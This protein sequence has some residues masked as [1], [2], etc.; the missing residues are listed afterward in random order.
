LAKWD[1]SYN[2]DN[3]SAHQSNPERTLESGDGIFMK[4]LLVAPCQ[5][6]L[7]DPTQGHSLIGVFHEIKIQIPSNAPEL[8]N[9]AIVPREWA[10]FSKFELD[11]DEEGKNYSMTTQFYWP[12]G[13]EFANQVLVA[14]QPTKNGMAFIS[15]FQGFPMGQNGTLKVIATLR[16]DDEVVC[17]PT[18]VG[19][20]VIVEKTPPAPSGVQ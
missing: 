20:K 7:Q 4:L 17:G 3:P 14:A 13:S 16:R 15:R 5:L 18:E 2:Y 8:P 11:P 9:N 10:I 19:I 1:R 12:D 6:A